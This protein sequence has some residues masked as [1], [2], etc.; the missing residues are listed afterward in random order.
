MQGLLNVFRRH[1]S[2]KKTAWSRYS[3]LPRFC[4]DADVKRGLLND[5]AI[6]LHS[7]CT[8]HCLLQLCSVSCTSCCPCTVG[9]GRAAHMNGSVKC[10]GLPTHP[11]C[12]SSSLSP[13]WEMVVQEAPQMVSPSLDKRERSTKQTD[14]FKNKTKPKG[15]R[16]QTF[17][18][19]G[20][21]GSERAM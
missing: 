18:E 21:I 16:E 10:S 6:S 14:L 17:S 15:K 12:N 5:S 13:A 20:Q 11:T 1:G 7:M 3:S 19:L 8:R 2:C 4:D 9:R